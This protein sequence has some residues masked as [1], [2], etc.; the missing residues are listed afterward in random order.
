MILVANKIVFDV[1]RAERRNMFSVLKP[2]FLSMVFLF[3][4]IFTGVAQEKFKLGEVPA[5]DLSMTVYP[6]DTS[7]IAV[8]LYE[9]Y[10]LKYNVFMNDF[11]VVTS[12]TIR[13]K[14]LKSAGLDKA[15]ISIPFYTGSSRIQSERIF[16][17]TG[18]TYN[19]DN[20]KLERVKLSKENIFEEKTSDSWQRIKI[21]FPNVKVGSIFELKY[22]KSSPYYSSLDDFVFQSSIPVRYS[23]CQVTI[24]EYFNFRRRTSG[25]E[26]I[27]YSERE[28]N[29]IFLFDRGNKLSCNGREMTFVATNLPAMKDDSYVWNVKDYTSRVTFDLMNVRVPGE[30]YNE[31]STTWAD[32]DKLLNEHEKFGKQIWLSNLMKD[33]LAAT[34]KDNLSP[35]DKVVAILE[36]V[37][38]KIQWNDEITLYADNVRKALREG[39]G[40]SAEMNAVLI[41]LLRDAGFNA[42][43]VVMGLRSRGRIFSQFPTLKSLNYF[44]TGVDIEGKPAYIDASEKYGTVNVISPDCM[45]Q[46]ARSI[47][48]DRPAI[49]V[50]LHEIGQNSYT[51]NIVAEF[52]EDGKLSGTV[53]R[54]MTGVPYM[55]YCRKVDKQKSEEDAQEELET[56]LNVLITDFEQG[57]PQNESVTEKFLFESN[58]TT[59]GDNF[60]YINS[61]VFPHI[62]ENPFKMETRK[63]PVEYSYPYNHTMSVSLIIPDGYELDEAP[64]SEI[65][66]LGDRQ[67]TYSYQVQKGEK[68]VQIVQQIA[69]KQ[70]LYPTMEYERVRNFWAN[71]AGKNNA[72]LVLKRLAQ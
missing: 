1:E 27:N 59:L 9:D 54:I 4:C 28:V 33:D 43:P 53:E 60:I 66:N 14:I 45:V 42:Y 58:E 21:A 56:E 18:Y 49:W 12:H 69:V 3:F 7:A 37:K 41:S 64:V 5:A 50:D 10:T 71:I 48:K 31:F 15:N 20:G 65:I 13:I 22:E 52:N 8:V 16:G 47:F 32:I 34:L 29:L 38:E 40:S 46:E 57:K 51:T 35:N 63:L 39:K 70:T 44:L 67:I 68:N 72:Q 36:L 11:Q 23:R 17:I 25:Y 62:K 55:S 30:F 19:L 6:E 26:S 61:L 24:P 2:Y